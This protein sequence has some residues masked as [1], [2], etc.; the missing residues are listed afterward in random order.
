MCE[1]LVGPKLIPN[2]EVDLQEVAKHAGRRLRD[3]SDTDY[4]DKFVSYFL[5][6]PSTSNSRTSF[7]LTFK[8]FEEREDVQRGIVAMGFDDENILVHSSVSI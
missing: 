3:T 7:E 1:V 2:D 4:I 8:P 5:Q 6:L